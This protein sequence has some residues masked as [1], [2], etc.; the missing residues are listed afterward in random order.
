MRHLHNDN[1][2]FKFQKYIIQ[3]QMQFQISIKQNDP[4]EIIA[5]F[6]TRRSKTFN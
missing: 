1:M 5:I 6:S 3:Q 2:T 4:R